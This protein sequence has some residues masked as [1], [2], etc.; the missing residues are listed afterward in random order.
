MRNGRN[1]SLIEQA[2]DYV[3][4]AVEKSGPILADA[5]DKA[6]AAV[7]EAREQAGP[8]LADA[9]DKATPLIV[10]GAAV[11][12][13]KASQAADLASAKAAEAKDLT[14]TKLD[15]LAGKPKKKHRVRKLLILTGIAALLA[16]L[17]KKLRD[18]ADDENW[19]SSYPT[20]APG[21]AGAADEG[22]AAPDEVL[23]DTAEEAHDATT[24]DEPADVVDVAPGEEPVAKKS[25]KP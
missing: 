17:A 25:A 8:A 13:A 16:F 15:E 7:A 6:G 14:A 5:K 21:S 20:P 11:A 9:R 4:A 2:A 10:Q 12:A 23:A 22:G 24:P 18:S 19:Q 1:K 3:E